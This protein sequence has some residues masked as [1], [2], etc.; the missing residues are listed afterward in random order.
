MTDN[1][2]STVFSNLDEWANQRVPAALYALGE[3]YARRG[4]AEM[5]PKSAARWKDFTSHARQ[6]LFGAVRQAVMAIFVRFAHTMD[7]GVFLELA[8]S[9]KYAVLKPTV[10]RLAPEFVADAKRLVGKS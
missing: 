4:E 5:K 3:H 8:N 1:G 6:G 10:E 7:Y 2:L 9:G